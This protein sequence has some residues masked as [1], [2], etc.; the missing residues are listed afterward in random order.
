MSWN[1]LCYIVGTVT[2]NINDIYD[3]GHK[4]NKL[5][6]LLLVNETAQVAIRTPWGLTERETMSNC[7]ARYCVGQ[8]I[9][10]WNYG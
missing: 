3:A 1:G 5:N 6:L 10:H 7:H 9:L 2:E 8:F 4:N